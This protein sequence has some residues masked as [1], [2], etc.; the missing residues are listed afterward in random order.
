MQR[1]AGRAWRYVQSALLLL[2]SSLT[3]C[4]QQEQD[5]KQNTYYLV[6]PRP[7]LHSSSSSHMC[8]MTRPS[9]PRQEGF[10]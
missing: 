5:E 6:W 8:T 1:R 7:C 4:G 10:D 2:L 3:L 9:L